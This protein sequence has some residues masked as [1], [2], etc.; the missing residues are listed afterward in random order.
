M[1]LNAIL[2]ALFAASKPDGVI[3]ATPNALHVQGG[4]E[5]ITA[6]VPVIVEKPIGDIIVAGQRLVNPATAAGVPLLTCH[7]RNY[8]AIMARLIRL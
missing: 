1:L 7:N 5:C 4:L 6:R 3:L 8:S 2:T